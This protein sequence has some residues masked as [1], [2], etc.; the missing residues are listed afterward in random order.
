MARATDIERVADEVT[1]RA[2]GGG[3]PECQRAAAVETLVLALSDDWVRQD[4]DT[5]DAVCSALETL[6]VMRRVGNLVFELLPETELA[7]CDRAPIQRCRRMAPWEISGTS[8]L[9]AALLVTVVLVAVGATLWTLRMPWPQQLRWLVATAA[10]DVDGPGTE[11]RRSCSARARW[12]STDV[13]ADGGW[14]TVRVR[15]AVG[16]Q[17]L[18]LHCPATLTETAHLQR[19]EVARTPLLL[20]TSPDGESSLHGPRHAVTGLWPVP[21]NASRTD[22]PVSPPG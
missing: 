10:A 18:E 3:W 13:C 5:E 22:A 14:M 12:W 16:A 20:I 17:L 4:P 15:S 6:G 9:T 1:H 7:E 8:V 19:W 11:L 21:A 2:A